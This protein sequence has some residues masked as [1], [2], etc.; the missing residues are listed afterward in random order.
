MKKYMFFVLGVLFLSSC[1]ISQEPCEGVA[2]T[3]EHESKF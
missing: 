2:D 1:G 3:Q